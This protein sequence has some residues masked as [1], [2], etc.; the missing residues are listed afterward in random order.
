MGR[1]AR[2]EYLN[3]RATAFP[4]AREPVIS[5]DTKKLEEHCMERMNEHS[6]DNQSRL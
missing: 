1:N 2:F 4:A 5:V 3:D 6:A